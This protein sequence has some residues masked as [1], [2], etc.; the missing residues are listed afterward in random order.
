M[1]KGM[2]VLLCLLLFAITAGAGAAWL[3]L[4]PEGAMRADLPEDVM[5][6]WLDEKDPDF[7]K[8]EYLRQIRLPVTE[9]EDG[10]AL[11]GKLYDA[12]VGEAEVRFS[13]LSADSGGDTRRYLIRLG[14]AD[15]FQAAVQYRDST[16]QVTEL[17]AL[18]ALSAATHE[19]SVLLPADA[20]LT[21]NGV[22]VG[23]EY[24]RQSGLD[25]PDMTALELGDPHRPT[26]KLYTVSGLYEAPRVEADR[27]NGLVLLSA[28]D[29]VWE[30]TV[31]DAAGYAFAVSAP[32]SA[33]VFLGEQALGSENIAATSV[34]VTKLDIPEELQGYLP[35]YVTYT[36]GGLYTLPE[37]SART[38]DGTALESAE[39]NGV[40][41][42][43]LPGT[44]ELRQ[45]QHQR[46]EDF[47]Q[48]LTKLG[49]GNGTL[50]AAAAYVSP[51]SQVQLYMGRAMAS[52]HWTRNVTLTFQDVTADS[53]VPLG[54]NAYL[55][56]ARAQFTT[57]TWYQ[58]KEL[59]WDFEMLWRNEDG[60]WML[61]DLAFL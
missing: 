42:F 15:L 25:Y 49:A 33:T 3:W 30:Y 21:V 40:L 29:G 22:A 28:A 48:A 12:A 24:L 4:S 13:P 47:I 5:E 14:E 57:K 59:S 23:E 26:R 50:A 6:A 51:D 45:A 39:V 37:I 18:D 41:T 54:E 20:A 9:F 56:R 32:R 36:A 60:A 7:W 58:T 2:L 55:C 31:P 44:E 52:L 46:A 34:Y 27:E 35:E 38:G 10:Q 53:Y 61:W 1:K 11:L 17:S 16:W 19:I 43:A 8:E